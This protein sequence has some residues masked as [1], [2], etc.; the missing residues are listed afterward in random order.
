LY[1]SADQGFI[2]T[3]N[4]NNESN[5]GLIVMLG[6][7]K[8]LEGSEQRECVIEQQLLNKWIE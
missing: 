3:D 5:K 6:I 7:R 2:V 1:R 8:D 4:K